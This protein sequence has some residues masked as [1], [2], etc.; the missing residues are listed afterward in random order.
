MVH[1]SGDRSGFLPLLIQ[2]ARNKKVSGY[3]GEGR[4]VWP[5]VHRLDLARLFRLALENGKAGSVYHGVGEVGIPFREIAEVIGKRVGVPVASKAANHFG[6]LAPFVPADNPASS[7]LTEE[8]LNWN[9][10]H[11]PLMEDLEGDLYFGS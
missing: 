2:T 11:P 1:G 8:Q 10:T 5:T 9:P 6:F 7:E 3:V 4:N